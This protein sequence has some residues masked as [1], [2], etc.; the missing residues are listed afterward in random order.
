MPSSCPDWTRAI[1]SVSVYPSERVEEWIAGSNI[2]P[3][4]DVSSEA[5]PP[6][7]S[8]NTYLQLH[9]RRPPFGGALEGRNALLERECLAD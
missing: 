6:S 2:K 5:R 7:S 3:G 1:H 8:L 4:N 9:I